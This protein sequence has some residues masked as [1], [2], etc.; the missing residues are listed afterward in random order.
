VVEI[1]FDPAISK[2]DTAARSAIVVGGQARVGEARGR[3]FCLE[4][5]AGHWSVYEQVAKLLNA[6]RRW[7]AR[8]IRIEKVAYQESIAQ[9]LDHEARLA[10]L[11]VNVELVEPDAD[12]LRRANAWAPLVEDG[13]ILFGPGQED[14]EDSMNA[15]PGDPSK[16]DLVDAGGFCF[17][18][19]SLLQPE[20]TRLPGHELTTPKT[21]ESYAVH[22]RTAVKTDRFPVILHGDGSD[23]ARGYAV[24]P[25]HKAGRPAP[26]RT[27]PGYRSR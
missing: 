11:D 3:I 13:T 21:A 12:K 6:Y 4:A 26:R 27:S 1:G 16:W 5:E 18:G 14:L 8:A 25:P 7:H 15:I 23:R 20:R 2:K 9:V 19:F 22:S 10:G 24:K 17:R